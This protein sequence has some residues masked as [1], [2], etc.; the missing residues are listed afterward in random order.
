MFFNGFD[1]KVRRYFAEDINKYLVA[2]Y[3]IFN[4][5]YSED[6]FDGLEKGECAFSYSVLKEATKIDSKK[7]VKI[8]KELEDEEFLT[9]TFK[10]KSR[11]SKSKVKLNLIEELP[12]AK[13][14]PKTKT[15]SKAVSDGSEDV[16]NEIWSLY[17]KKINKKQGLLAL[18]RLLKAVDVEMIKRSVINYKELCEARGTDS[19]YIMHASTFFN[20]RWEEF[21]EAQQIQPS[22][23]R[24]QAPAPA[25]VQRL[26]FDKIQELKRES[27][28]ER[29]ANINIEEALPF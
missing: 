9:W 2:S 29:R 17:P 12:K 10:S 13:A 21:K 16:L 7:L 3:L 26:D 14:K 27:G 19:Q 28:E 20:G 5:N 1:A 15:K 8:V 4:A 24:G 18:K 6:V 22:F 23:R 11:G 25:P